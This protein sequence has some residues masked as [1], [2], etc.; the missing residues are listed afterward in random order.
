MEEDSSYVACGFVNHNSSSR[1][2][3]Q[4]RPRD[5]TCKELGVPPIQGTLY[6]TRWPGG[7]LVKGDYSQLELKLLASESQDEALLECYA[8]GWDLHARTTLGYADLGVGAFAGLVEAGAAACGQEL[9][10]GLSFPERVALAEKGPRWKWCR[11]QGKRVNF[12]SGYGGGASVL[13]AVLAEAGVFLPDEECERLVDGW[14]RIYPRVAECSARVCAEARGNAGTVIAP[15]GRKRRLPALIWG[16]RGEQGH[17]EREAGN[18]KI[19]WM[20]AKLTMI[21][22]L[23]L[24]E[25]L[26]GLGARSLI[27]GTIHDSIILDSPADEAEDAKVILKECME[28]AAHDPRWAPAGWVHTS[29]RITADVD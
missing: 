2:N 3:E 9:R 16:D 24:D 28:T 4:N 10:P 20:A 13:Q 1:P 25:V 29:V 21:A 7:E 17:A 11:T 27:V 12:L 5:D 23:I 19:Q 14:H 8:S 6:T 15:D 26:R 18:F 22:L